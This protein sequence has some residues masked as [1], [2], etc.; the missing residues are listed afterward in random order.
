MAF[1]SCL[2]CF[3]KQEEEVTELDY[4]HCSLDDVPNDV[5]AYERTLEVLHL[6]SN[7]IRDL[8]RPLF[9]CH[10]LRHL[11]LADNELGTIP[12]ALSSLSQLVTLDVSKNVLTDIPETIKQCKQLAVIEASVN[13]LQKIPEGC[14][15]LVSL[16]ELYLNDCFLEFI[17]ANFGRLAKLKILEL[18]ENSLNSLPK[19]MDRLVNLTRIDLSQNQFSEVPDILGA[20]TELEELWLDGN[21]LKTLPAMLGR[22]S[23]LRH[24]DASFNHLE[25]VAP[26]IGNCTALINLTLSTNDLKEVPET[27]ESLVNLVTLKL[28]DNQ[29]EKLPENLGKM[30]SLEELFCAENFLTTLP[31]SIGWLR[32][33]HTLNVD[34]N[35][36]EDFPPE[37]G[38][39]RNM[40]ILS[41]HGNKL[42][43]L[44]DELGHIVNLAVLNLAGNF[45]PHLPV[46]FV[47]LKSITAIWLANNQ[48]KPL[49]QLN[50][51]TDPYTGEKVLTNFLL[52]QQPEH[53]RDGDNNSDSGSFHA[54]VWE[55]ERSKRSL[56]KWAG[57]DAL[58]HDKT[59]NLRRAP[60][61][62]PKEMRAMAKKVQSMREK[63]A[64]E[65]D[66]NSK[67]RQSREYR[68]RSSRNRNRDAEKFRVN[69]H[70]QYQQEENSSS[71]FA[72]SPLMPERQ[73]VNLSQ[74]EQNIED[75]MTAAMAQV[76]PSERWTDSRKSPDKLSRDSGVTSPSDAGSVTTECSDV[77]IGMVNHSSMFQ[78][79]SVDSSTKV[80]SVQS[81]P[82]NGLTMHNAPNNGLQVHNNPSIPQQSQPSNFVSPLQNMLMATGSRRPSDPL[83]HAPVHQKLANPNLAPV[84]AEIVTNE[85]DDEH[86][87]NLKGSATNQPP[88]YHIAAAMSKHASDFSNLHRPSH[89]QEPEEHYYENQ[90]SMNKRPAQSASL[91]R[92][93]S[94][95]SDGTFESISES[96]TS[97]APSSLQT[98][99]RAP[100]ANSISQYAGLSEY[101]SPPESPTP[102]HVHQH[103]TALLTNTANNKVQN[104]QTGESESGL[105]SANNLRK[106]SEQLLTNG[107]TRSSLSGPSLTRPSSNLSRPSSV[108]L[109]S[110]LTNGI[111]RIPGPSSIGQLSSGSSSGSRPSSQLSHIYPSPSPRPNSQQG[112]NG[113][114]PQTPSRIPQLPSSVPGRENRP[115]SF[116]GPPNTVGLPTP[117]ADQTITGLPTPTM[118]PKNAS[119]IP[120]LKQP[121]SPNPFNSSL[122]STPLRYSSKLP[123]F[124]SEAISSYGESNGLLSTI[125]QAA[126]SDDESPPATHKPNPPKFNTAALSKPTV[127]HPTVLPNYENVQNKNQLNT[128]QSNIPRPGSLTPRPLTTPSPI[129]MTQGQ[130]RAAASQAK[131]ATIPDDNSNST[132][133]PMGSRTLIGPHNPIIGQ[134][135][136]LATS[137]PSARPT[138][139]PYLN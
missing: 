93:S 105:S 3:T 91:E 130:Y 63:K 102:P 40:K 54:S 31:P 60:T 29:I 15:Q 132:Y 129:M 32:K 100:Y 77:N 74:E 114:T 139:M 98:I 11:G 133:I 17:P 69:L 126:I 79:E 49:V 71:N 37:I 115:N 108:A 117:P 94:F 12:Q 44:P 5:F 89:T 62:F 27:L 2:S 70:G 34:E 88:P 58:D 138:Y 135:I 118:I 121:A 68:G 107:R 23:K 35:D 26:D 42:T 45:I 25:S 103:D 14:T 65:D 81:T 82:S 38:S 87:L 7:N 123:R 21:R 6:D 80:L 90:E 16:T 57:E 134:K 41:A 101:D 127:K 51:D 4:R 43:G 30:A 33:L 18:R 1:L 22:F 112:Y 131:V 9:H 64:A 104:G 113:S 128:S 66:R 48:T 36:L 59:G 28:D 97:T 110:P 53:D 120:H 99:V 55:E 92:K 72:I 78:H 52:P 46:S 96:E 19:S 13:P 67:R 50:H 86:K 20:M 124:N 61:P 76:I 73:T 85:L 116:A 84:K 83:P 8:P 137:S 111:S 39:C 47:K 75:Q 122:S 125:S 24:L 10:G 136:P 106:V 95:L 109:A 56:V 119:N